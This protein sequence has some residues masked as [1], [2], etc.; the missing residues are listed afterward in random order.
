MTM[1]AVSVRREPFARGDV[2]RRVEPSERGCM[3]CGNTR[4]NGTLFRYGW[5]RDDTGKTVWD[6]KQFCSKSCRDAYSY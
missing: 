4:K 3:F 2:M 5:N 1:Q 6:A